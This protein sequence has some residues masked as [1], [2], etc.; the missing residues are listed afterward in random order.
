MDYE[1]GMKGQ[2]ELAGTYEAG[3]RI[4]ELILKSNTV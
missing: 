2:C 1:S 4:K 3:G